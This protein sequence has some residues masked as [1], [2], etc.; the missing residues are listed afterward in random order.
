LGDGVNPTTT[1]PEA[2]AP[3]N[4]DMRRAPRRRARLHSARLFDLFTGELIVEAAVRDIS[5]TGMQL[6]L[7]H[8]CELPP[9]LH[10]YGDLA[11]DG[12]LCMI[13][14][15]NERQLGV[16]IVGKAAPRPRREKKPILPTK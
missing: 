12:A 4:R 3:R 5:A 7:A 11:D 1:R 9:R 2:A 10:I 14:W 16:R 8:M 13:V 15:R 6:V